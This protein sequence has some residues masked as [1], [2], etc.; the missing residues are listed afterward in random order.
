MDNAAIETAL[1]K[2]KGKIAPAAREL[3]CSRAHLHE[4]VKTGALAAR[5]K[6]IRTVGKDAVKN[7]LDSLKVDPDEVA[8]RAMT[9]E[10]GP[11]AATLAVIVEK[12]AEQTGLAKRELAKEIGRRK[13]THRMA[14]L[15]PAAP[16]DHGSKKVVPVAISHVH[17]AWLAPQAR[18]TVP[19]LLG[20]MKE[21][22]KVDKAAPLPALFHTSFLLPKALHRTLHRVAD[23][24]GASVSALVR[25]VLDKAMADAAALAPA[26]AAP[27]LAA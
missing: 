9:H 1:V 11:H 16:A 17:R 3:G 23:D 14:E 18:G 4:Q 19:A 5:L 26:P 25:A 22:P 6:Q 27:P 15:L 7:A 20:S 13:Y 24:Q 10:E 2:H 12:L 8:L 21:W